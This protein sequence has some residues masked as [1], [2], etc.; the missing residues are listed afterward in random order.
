MTS[1]ESGDID[2]E[3][4]DRLR[5]KFEPMR[6]KNVFERKK[7]ELTIVRLTLAR[8]EPE[9]SCNGPLSISRP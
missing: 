8:L 9:R 4:Y 3:M 6:I 2:L 1:R 7:L 5:V